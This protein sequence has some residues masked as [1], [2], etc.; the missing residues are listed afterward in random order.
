[1]KLPITLQNNG[2]LTVEI[3]I[4]ISLFVLFTISIFSLNSSMYGINTW[5]LKELDMLNTSVHDMDSAILF[6]SSTKLFYGNNSTII[7]VSPFEIV[8]SDFQKGWGDS[9]CSTNIDFEISSL[10]YFPN[11]IYLGSGNISTGINSKNSIIYLTSD[12]PTQSQAD[13]FIINAEDF[14]NPYI[15]SSLNTGPGL[16]SL[17]IAGPYAYVANTSSLS[18]LQIIDI[19]DR[20]FP[21]IVSQLKLPLP[22]ASSTPPRAN[23]IF[24]RNGYVYLGTNKWD[25]AEFNIIDVSNPLNPI[26]ISSFETNTLIND[27]YVYENFAFLATSDEN[28]MR[29]IDINNKNNIFL[30]HTFTAD[31]WQVQQGKVIAYFENVLALGRTVGGIN[32]I[33]NHEAFVFSTSS[34]YKIKYSQDIPGGVYG[35]LMRPPYNFLIS[36]TPSAEFQVWNSDFSLKLYEKS[37][38]LKPVVISCDSSNLFLANGDEKGFS[39]IKLNQ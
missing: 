34:D 19:H 30:T 33:L 31:G 2:F 29:I 1:M 25:G 9:S 12:S 5:S 38:G 37:L 26:L 20:N 13:F 21:H 3:M 4:S 32:R 36:H 11:G 14:L 28:Q 23:S 16:A 17:A 7:K 39:I 8:K 10:Q 22:N 18:Q 6:S 24:Y 27:I 35:F 15:I